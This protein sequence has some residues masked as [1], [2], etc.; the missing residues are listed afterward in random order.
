MNGVWRVVAAREIYVKLHDKTFLFA[1]G[2]L[3][4]I[5]AAALFV[6]TLIDGSK[7]SVGVID[8]TSAAV[9]ETADTDG[10]SFTVTTY[11]DVA[12]IEAALRAESLDVALLP[13]NDGFELT[14][15]TSIDQDVRTTLTDA[16]ARVQLQRNAEEAGISMAVLTAD[17]D[18]SKRLLDPAPFPPGVTFGLTFGFAMVF[19]IT[20]LAFGMSLA[21][22][23]VQEKETRIV[24][25]LAAAIPVRAL[26]AGKVVASA[27]LALGQLVLLTATSLVGL[28]LSGRGNMLA[29][30]AGPAAWYVVFFILGFIALEGIFAVAGAMATRNEDLQSTTLP[31][32]TI[33]IVPLFVVIYANE[34]VTAVASYVPIASSFAMPSRMLSTNVTWWQPA[35]AA[36]IVL[37]TAVGLVLLAAR[38]Y[39]RSLLKTQRKLTYREAVG[40]R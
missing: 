25:I 28:Q 5:I 32:Q 19:Y 8:D 39:E 12:A 26:L 38:I 34:T 18:V 21:Q 33:L 15:N 35:L 9:V 16:V 37:A 13:T 40:I 30:L 2:F 1:T 29:E 3:I 4:L 23:V 24:E 10:D 36:I 22:S 27:V 7:T 11:D 31:A 20:T 14:A 17:T 6:P